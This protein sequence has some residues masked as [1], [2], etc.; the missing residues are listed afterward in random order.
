MLKRFLT[1]S[2]QDHGGI[3]KLA[4]KADWSEAYKILG[5][6]YFDKDNWT[7]AVEA[8]E[9]ADLLTGGEDFRHR[10]HLAIGYYHLGQRSQAKDRYAEGIVWLQNNP[11]EKLE[12]LRAEVEHL[13]G[14]NEAPGVEIPSKNPSVG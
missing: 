6:H 14:L 9:K 3:E 5:E 1:E 4:S 8:L 11:N 2:I 7:E 13:L 10:L 12:G